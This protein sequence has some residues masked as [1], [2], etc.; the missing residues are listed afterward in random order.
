MEESSSSVAAPLGARRIAVGAVAAAALGAGAA[1][2]L[3]V[4]SGLD[5]RPAG[6]SPALGLTF[7]VPVALFVFAFL[8]PPRRVIDTPLAGAGLVTLTGGA[9]SVTLYLLLHAQQGAARDLLDAHPPTVG[10]TIGVSLTLVLA[11][12]GHLLQRSVR[13]NRELRVALHEL[14]TSESKFRRFAEHIHDVFW[15]TDWPSGRVTYV[16]P[17]Y[18]E[19]WGRSRQDLAR[20]DHEIHEAVHADDQERV[21]AAYREAAEREYDQ[22]YR[23]VRPDGDVRWVHDR[24]VALKDDAGVTRQ[25]LGVAKDITERKV[26][27]AAHK[28]QREQLTQLALRIEA[29][30]EEERTDVAREIHDVLGQALTAI[31]L[32][33]NWVRDRARD[34]QELDEERLVS[35]IKLLDETM[36]AGR[37]LSARLRPTVLDDLGLK[38]ALDWQVR[39]FAQ[40]TGLSCR[41]S[42]LPEDLVPDDAR[43]T[44]L[45][46]ILQEALT[47]V[48]RHAKSKRVTVRLD[49]DG[50]SL[51]L[52]V[53]DDGRGIRPAEIDADA[54]LGLIGMRERADALGGRFT[55]TPA[56]GGGT[57]VTAS[58]PL[59]R[60]L[61]GDRK[62]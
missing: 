7:A 13:A 18:E 61:R 33:L 39:E 20:V 30:R 24:G 62:T 41:L 50:D 51:R 4:A 28:R 36:D 37:R 45:F 10:L 19:I 8:A 1:G 9:F 27:E 57:M 60:R 3:C 11:A 29:I 12:T 14:R 23:V 5:G 49:R 6:W 2:L 55:V 21:A 46:R 32:D 59:S 31:Q 26:G 42:I 25:I 15:I 44:A 52:T 38:A 34:G 17:A 40:R 53:R 58:I 54:S 35:M 43:D 56:E 16:S 22:T 48:T 47:N